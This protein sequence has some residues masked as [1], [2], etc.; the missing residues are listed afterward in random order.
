MVQETIRKQAVK[1]LDKMQMNLSKFQLKSFAYAAQN[2]PEDTDI[3]E[4]YLLEDLP[5]V[6]GEINEQTEEFESSGV[7][8]KGNA[9]SVK[10]T[11]SNSV[12]AKWLQWGTN[13]QT[14]PDIRRG[15]RVLIYQYNDNDEYY[16][17][18]TGLDDH[19][20]RLETLRVCLSNTTDESTKKLTP[21]N[22]YYVEASTK[23]KLITLQ[24][25][26]S[27][28]EEFAY[29]IQVDTGNSHVIITDDINN[30]IVIESKEKRITLENADG[31]KFVLD[32]KNALWEVPDTIKIKAKNT[33]I[34][35][36]NFKLQAKK[37]NFNANSA[38]KGS[39]TSN[40]VNISNTHTHGGV[41]SGK[42]RTSTPS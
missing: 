21:D 20:R 22:T 4:V 1:G 6:D 26:K 11:T 31:A 18:S 3:L 36:T 17:V 32:K 28:K 15:E 38:F 25:S 5:Y 39:L 24:T 10:V 12:S 14:R 37:A 7:D 2:I 42:S 16:W 8:A 27:N 29:T 23:T 35:T 41:D 30:Q 19:L 34:E 40:D 33:N 13:R 9:Y